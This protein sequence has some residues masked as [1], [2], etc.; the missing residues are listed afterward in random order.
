MLQGAA[1]AISLLG[2][3]LLARTEFGTGY[4]VTT[5]Q[6]FA[7]LSVALVYGW[8]LSPIAAA[9]SGIRGAFLALALLDVLWVVLGQGIAG[10]IFCALPVCPDF[11]PWGDIVRIGS[12]VLGIVAAR[13]A[14]RAY[15]ALTGPTQWAPAVTALVLIA[16]SFT[17]QG[18]NAKLP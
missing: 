12:L 2:Y 7:L 8:W 15:R 1:V 6:G 4:Q 11:A 5:G 13:H 16:I 14:W 18:T 17:L 9:T 3:L 10:L